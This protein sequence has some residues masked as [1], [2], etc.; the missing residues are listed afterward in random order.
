[1]NQPLL[2]IRNLVKRFGG[3]V[4]TNGTNLSIHS[5]EI[6][7]LIGPNGAGK[8]TLIHQISGALNSDEGTMIFD[9]VDIFDMPMHK[10]VAAGLARSYQITS[11]FKKL[12][13][14]DNVAL[15]V[16][17][18]SGSSF[19][20]W[21]AAISEAALFNE[22]HQILEQVGLSSKA[23]TIAG[24]LA[25]GEQRQLEL[26]I[27]LGTRP[28][29]LLLDEPMAGMGPEDSEKMVELLMALKG[30]STV[31]LIEHDMAAV[32]RLA[33]RMSALVYGRVIATGVPNAVR[34]DPEVKRAY[35]G[36]EAV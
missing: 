1:M 32:F 14:L 29:L 26:G 31:L 17:A 2:E 20:F 23:K 15:S 12:T 11:I 30:K 9:G 3:L 34:E 6:H 27:T 16:Q 36:E 19:R 10:R 24:S 18:R 25:H 35:L 7:A 4:A 13:V 8:T 22:A 5:G 33:D 28:K 21:R